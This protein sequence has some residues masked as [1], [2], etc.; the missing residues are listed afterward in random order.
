MNL[1][2]NSEDPDHSTQDMQ[3]DLDLHWSCMEFYYYSMIKGN[4]VIR[5][6]FYN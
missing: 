2:T 6:N 5:V 4:S 3:G 1:K